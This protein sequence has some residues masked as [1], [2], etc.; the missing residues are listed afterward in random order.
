M[1]T[2]AA[3]TS[4]VG[5]SPHTRAVAFTPADSGRPRVAVYRR[6]EPDSAGVRAAYWPVVGVLVEH[7]LDLFGHS[8]GSRV[9]YAVEDPRTG[10]IRAA[11]DMAGG[12]AGLAFL[13][14]F[15]IGRHPRWTDPVFEVGS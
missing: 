13:G 14:V 7:T 1:T 4:A 5:T 6:P 3:P 2:S 15:E 11:A 10:T 12:R 9:S 8:T